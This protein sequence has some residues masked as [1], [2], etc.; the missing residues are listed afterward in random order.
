MKVFSVNALAELF[1]LD[2]QTVV[3][4]LRGVQ[5]DAK[6]KNQPRWRMKTA[7]AAIERHRSSNDGNTGST[8]IDPGLAEAYATFDTAFAAMEAEPILVKRRALALKI[9]PLISDVDSR[10]RAHGRATGI[11][12]ELADYRAQ[13]ILRLTL[14]GFEKPCAWSR[15]E[16]HQHLVV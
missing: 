11:G 5:A 13:E 10:L 14:L 12:D 4:A 2:R 6:E 7:G 8:G 3:R 15:S 1:E 16:C 9:A